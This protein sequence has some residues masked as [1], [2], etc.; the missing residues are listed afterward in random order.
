MSGLLLF[1]RSPAAATAVCRQIESRTV[2]KVY[3]ARVLGR[4]PETPEGQP[5]VVDVPLDWDPVANKASAVPGAEVVDGMDE[6][7]NGNGGGESAAA[8]AAGAGDEGSGAGA[9]AAAGE[10]G[11]AAMAAAAEEVEGEA[12]AAPGDGDEPTAGLSK[13][14]LK[15]RRKAAVRL[16]KAQRKAAR[17]VR[18]AAAAEA[19]AA[20]KSRGG[21]KLPKAAVTEYRLLGVAADGLTSVVECR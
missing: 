12:A 17:E 14:E 2:Q 18:L 10:S 16:V 3:V 4:F 13:S 11:D 15:A 1:A 21:R 19:A 20:E 8:G 7:G 5:I 9:A 6:D